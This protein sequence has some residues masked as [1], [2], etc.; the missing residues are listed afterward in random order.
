MS[1]CRWLQKKGKMW[2]LVAEWGPSGRETG[3]PL[4]TVNSKWACIS[5]EWKT[6]VLISSLCKDIPPSVPLLSLLSL[7]V[8]GVGGSQHIGRNFSKQGRTQMEALPELLCLTE[9]SEEESWAWRPVS[10]WMK[11]SSKFSCQGVVMLTLD[12]LSTVSEKVV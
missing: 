1:S 12:F 10:L 8:T 5:W 3:R 11:I 9:S 6:T 7:K 4:K 2:Y